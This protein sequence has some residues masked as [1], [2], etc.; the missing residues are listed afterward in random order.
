MLVQIGPPQPIH[1]KESIAPPPFGSKGGDTLAC[2]VGGTGTQFLQLD[3]LELRVYCHPSTSKSI[4]TQTYGA[5]GAQINFGDLTLYLT[6]V[7]V[8]QISVFM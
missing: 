4:S 8:V 3:T 7:S 5:Q 2:E 6:Y 1:P